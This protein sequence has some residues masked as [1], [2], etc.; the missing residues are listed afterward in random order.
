MSLLKEYIL[1][2]Y[3]DNDITSIGKC[4]YPYYNT[5]EH[6]MLSLMINDPIAVEKCLSFLSEFR[7]QV[8]DISN[9]EN[10]S[11]WEL[12]HEGLT[13][14]A[15]FYV[16]DKLKKQAIK[17]NEPLEPCDYTLIHCGLDFV[18]D[19]SKKVENYIDYLCEIELKNWT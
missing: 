3:K 9:R 15:L 5:E 10:L 16:S 17:L 14:V 11:K 19:L 7:K 13:Y 1:D 4:F 18:Y 6:L 8:Q 2:G 12:E